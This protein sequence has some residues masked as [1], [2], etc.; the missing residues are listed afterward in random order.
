MWTYAVRGSSQGGCVYS[1]FI[2]SWYETRCGIRL[3]ILSLHAFVDK[4]EL[5]YSQKDNSINM[6]ETPAIPEL[7]DLTHDE[8]QHLLRRSL[9]RMLKRWPFW[10]ACIIGGCI[11]GIGWLV[12]EWF[13]PQG[14]P[15][16]TGRIL[17]H[18]IG[19][20][21]VLKIFVMVIRDAI[22]FEKGCSRN[23]H[24]ERNTPVSR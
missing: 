5:S 2:F 24:P 17:T 7:S 14:W 15:Q 10:T 16:T 23:L 22:R 20:S 9:P 6:H 19:F 1:E 11:E 21:I 13:L 18:F 12:C 3:S 4:L 8:R